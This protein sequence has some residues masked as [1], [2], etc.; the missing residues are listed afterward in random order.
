MKNPF[1]RSAVVYLV[2]LFLFFISYQS[3]RVSAGSF[4]KDRNFESDS[5]FQCIQAQCGQALLLTLRNEDPKGMK[6]VLI[7]A[8]R[9][10]GFP[11]WMLEYGKN[12]LFSCEK[13]AILFTGSLADTNSAW[14][15]QSVRRC[16]PDVAVL[17]MGMMDRLWLVDYWNRKYRLD[18]SEP[19]RADQNHKNTFEALVSSDHSY[20][21]KNIQVFIDIVR[22]NIQKR[23]VYLS[24]DVSPDFLKSIQDYLEIRGCVFKLHSEPLT[25][26]ASRLNIE[27]A[28]ILFL[29][30]G[31]FAALQN[32][33]RPD[34][35]ELEVIARHYRFAALMLMRHYDVIADV[36]KRNQIFHL[37]HDS[38][39]TGF[40]SV[41]E[42]FEPLGR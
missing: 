29:E 41:P 35:P 16:R 14:Y 34:C 27:G 7:R 17:P 40:V 28:E 31:G 22:K 11:G 1:T 32:R 21:Q 18:L 15:L 13:N 19:G 6:S 8:E 3:G 12:V 26:S 25:D 20:L 5:D 30:N 38:F 37:I 10:G 23:P 24:M 9:M 36:Q 4:P 2:L 33:I 39:E 42:S